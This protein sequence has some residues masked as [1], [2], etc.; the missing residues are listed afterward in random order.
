MKRIC[1]LLLIVCCL[2]GAVQAADYYELITLEALPGAEKQPDDWNIAKANAINNKGEVVGRATCEERPGGGLYGGVIWEPGNNYAP[3]EILNNGSSVDA[4]AWGINDGSY[5]VGQV[6][7]QNYAFLWQAASEQWWT[8][9]MGGT[10]ARAINIHGV[11]VGQEYYSNDYNT[12]LATEFFINQKSK[13][14]GNASSDT[15]SVAYGLND[16]GQAVGWED[17]PRTNNHTHACIWEKQGDAWVW[18]DLNPGWPRSIAQAINKNGEVTGW[19]LVDNIMRAFVWDKY[20]GMRTIP[21]PDKHETEGRA[22]NAHGHIVGKARWHI[23]EWET[24]EFAFIWFHG[25]DGIFDLN[26]FMPENMRGV[27]QFK[28]ATG[29]NDRLE[30]VLN[31][32]KKYAGDKVLNRA[33]VL[34]PKQVP[35]G[36]EGIAGI[37]NNLLLEK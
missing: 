22:I 5:V 3:R 34:R 1:L 14:M 11:I 32:T 15:E 26:A 17:S 7:N 6:E 24:Y 37:I 4:Q 31:G 10:N 28:E 23:S 33:F 8:L 21:T 29:I 27:C 30:I 18:Q 36:A 13:I 35:G 16:S 25:M 20:K 19:Y 2:A 9:R 12:T